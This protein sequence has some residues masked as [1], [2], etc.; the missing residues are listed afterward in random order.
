MRSATVTERWRP[1]VQP[2]AIVRWLLPSV[3]VGGDEELQQRQQAAVELAGLGAGLDVGAD[4][5]VHPGQRPQLVDVVGVGQEADV[6]GQVGVARRPVLEAEGEQ[7]QRQLAA[8]L[9]AQH[10]LGDPPPQFAAGQ[11]AGVHHHVGAL[12]QRRQQLALGPDPVDDPPFRRQ[13]MAAA[14]LLVAVEQGLLVGLEEEHLRLQPDRARGR[15][16]PGPGHR[17]TRRRARRRRPRR[18]RRRCPRG[19]RARRGCRSSAAA[20]CRRRSSRRPRRRRSP[21]TCRR[22]SGR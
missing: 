5:L 14:G 2:T 17:S 20:G 12:A 6:E 1:P 16:A 15:R 11:V 3:D 10:L 8:L 7:G 9:A 13:R 18:A 21:P 19:G 22:R 4:L